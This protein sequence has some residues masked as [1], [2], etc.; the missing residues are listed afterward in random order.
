MASTDLATVAPAFVEMAHRIVWCTTATASPDGEV[1]TRVLH[2]CWEWDGTSL[3]GWILTSPISPKARHLDANPRVSLT[4]W[5]ADHD[6]CSADCDTAWELSPEQRRA[7]WERF[8][9]APPP[10]GYDPRI[11]PIWPEPQAPAFGV[12]RLDP[13]WLRVMPGTV[14]MQGQGELLSWS[15]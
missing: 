12:L 13:T 7:G 8:A 6:T 5:A 2:P 9:T 11:I 15:A 14:M 10:V 1:K 3:T 4:Y